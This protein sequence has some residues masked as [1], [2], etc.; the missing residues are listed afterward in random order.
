[1]YSP[2][3]PHGNV[4]FVCLH[5]MVLYP[6]IRLIKLYYYELRWL[7]YIIIRAKNHLTLDSLP[8]TAGAYWASA[9]VYF[10]LVQ[11]WTKSFYH[12]WFLQGC[13]N[14]C[15]HQTLIF[16]L[17]YTCYCNAVFQE[18]MATWIWE[19]KTS[20]DWCTVKEV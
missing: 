5:I 12:E 15:S 7:T 20:Q 17:Q 4:W 19:N 6:R 11:S 10:S 13:K 3:L 1:M 16:S 18:I 8:N 9:L 14:L 2:N